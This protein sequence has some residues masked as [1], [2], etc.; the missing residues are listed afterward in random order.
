MTNGPQPAPGNGRAALLC[1]C[2]T[3]ALA[4]GAR[5]TE[6]PFWD[7]DLFRLGDEY[8]LAT[9][10]AYHWIAGAEGFEFG[11]GH[12]MSEAVRLISELVGLTPALTGFYLPVFM[13][14]LTGLG[15]FLW[16]A[17]LGRPWAGLCAGVLTSLTPGFCARTLLGFYDTDLVILFFAVMLGLVPAIGLAPYLKSPLEAL[18]PSLAAEAEATGCGPDRDTGTLLNAPALALF[19]LSGL[20]G[21]MT[22]EWHSIFPYLTR[23]SIFMLPCAILALGP[24]GGRKPLLAGALCHALPLLVGLPGF[25]CAALCAAAL[26]ALTAAQRSRVAAGETPGKRGS[27]PDPAGAPP[28]TPPGEM[29]SPGPPHQVG[30]PENLTEGDA[31]ACAVRN[32]AKVDLPK[33]LTE[34]DAEN[35]AGVA[36]DGVLSAVKRPAATLRA[37]S[38]KIGAFFLDGRA[39]FALWTLL[40][41]GAADAAVLQNMARSFIAYTRR[42]GDVSPLSPADGPLVFPSVSQSVIEVQTIDVHEMLLYVYPFE[43]PVLVGA[44]LFTLR[45]LTVPAMLWLLPLFVLHMLSL[46]MGARMTMF[47]APVIMITLCLEAGRLTE[48]AAAA[49]TG[50]GVR[51]PFRI[52]FPFRAR[53]P[54]QDTASRE[55]PAE[56]LPFLVRTAVCLLCAAV[57]SWPLIRHIPDYSQ[58]PI[59]SREQAEG[60][61][62]LRFNSPEDAMVWNWWDWGYAVHHFAGRRCIADGARH[63][64]PSLYLPAAV[65]TTEDPRFARQIIKYTAL[66]GDVPGNV[67]A[68]LSASGAQQLMRDL[69]NRSNP[70]VQASG[71]Q[72]LVVG[73]DLL[74]LGLWVTRYGSWNF[75]SKTAPGALMSNLTPALKYNVDRGIVLADESGPIYASTMTVFDGKNIERFDFNRYGAYHFIFSSRR[76]ENRYG[77]DLPILRRF[78]QRMRGPDVFSGPAGNKLVMDDVFYNTMMVQLLI[79]PPG[80]PEIAPYF[81]L[82]FDNV[83]TRIYQV[84]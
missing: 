33:N 37:W 84:L 14:A 64:G 8:L 28:R 77:G 51:F 9:H 46:R 72:Y 15:V 50:N 17:G 32:G 22:Q 54:V 78:W 40:C 71:T 59:I 83:Y 36:S 76:T 60:L 35:F 81:K 66:K 69:G 56:T 20:G 58:G 43:L 6:L 31:A 65:Y 47:G 74:H 2:L 39:L 70:L 3:L 53:A 26:T 42:G 12:P 1:L 29:I 18:F 44:G 62:F 25:L 21:Y 79:R 13:S 55:Q 75:E 24:P 19:A 63:G 16:C 23:F 68:G 57:F 45:V 30:L 73:F 5:L 38:E 27:A 67:F 52:R 4:A 10:D 61:K 7:N 48:V 80:D 82:V 41:I 49:L 11:A 34:G